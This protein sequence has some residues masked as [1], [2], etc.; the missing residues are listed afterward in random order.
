[1]AV[2]PVT[3]KIYVANA[4]DS[5]VTVIAEQT[6]YPTPPTTSIAPKAGS[7]PDNPTPTFTFSVQK[8]LT[9][10]KV[11]FAVD[12]LQ[13]AWTVASGSGS[14]FEG[15]IAPVEPGFHILYAFAA[16]SQESTSTQA[17][18]P[19]TGSVQTFGFVVTRPP[20]ATLPTTTILTANVAETNYG[21]PLHLTATVKAGIGTPSGK[22]TFSYGNRLLGAGTLDS[23]GKSTIITTV[24]P[25]GNDLVTASY[26]GNA[27]YAASAGTLTETIEPPIP[28]DVSLSPASG[29]GLKQAFQATYSDLLG[30]SDLNTLAI[31]FN[32]STSPSYACYVSYSTAAN[33][34]YLTNDAG[35]QTSPGMTPGSSSSTS[36]S[37]CTLEAAGSSVSTSGDAITVTFSLVFKRNF[38]GL[39]QAYLLSTTNEGFSSGAVLKGTWT[40]SAGIALSRISWVV[41][42]NQVLPQSG[43]IYVTNDYTQE[44]S[45]NPTILGSSAFTVTKTCPVLEKNAVCGFQVTYTPEKIENDKA[46]LYFNPVNGPPGENPTVSLT[47]YSVKPEVQVS[48]SSL[49]FYSQPGDSD[50]QHVY[51]TNHLPYTLNSHFV[52]ASNASFVAFV[53]TNDCSAIP[54]F[55][56]CGLNIAF[57]PSISG[58][59]SADIPFNFVNAPS[60]TLPALLLEGNTT[61]APPPVF[62]TTTN[63]KLV[64]L[65]GTS[66]S[67]AVS[68]SNNTTGTISLMPVVSGSPAFALESHAPRLLRSRHATSM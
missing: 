23:S 42:T 36:S 53:V 6:E 57:T 25:V 2:N 40:P 9:A 45:F 17:G 50:Y 46:T 11:A 58:T 37:Q 26:A 20:A 12:T 16:D 29:T 13:N 19:L 39:K 3:N 15:T 34:I 5:T 65:L 22:V 24:L 7:Q 48:K 10:P 14:S 59:F 66:T 33:A 56:I 49:Y 8:A 44:I 55:G 18:S 1:V 35:T 47:G 31:L 27:T 28:A 68:I 60:T 61:A 64:T 21:D 67:A 41:L 30:V 43:R 62:L 51:I 63:L 52:I 32:T 38:A 54:A 4:G